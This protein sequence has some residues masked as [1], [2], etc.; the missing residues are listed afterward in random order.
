MLETLSFFKIQLVFGLVLGCACALIGVF[1]LLQRLTVFGVTLSQAATSATAVSLFLGLQSAHG[2]AGMG[3]LANDLL[4]L[5][6][7]TLFML[8]FFFVKLRNP[9]NLSAI[10]VGGLVF[11]AALSQ[12]LIA[13]GGRVQ[14]HLLRAFFGNI[15]T[16]SSDEWRHLWIPGVVFLVFFLYYYRSILS[17]SFDRDHARLTGIK[18]FWIDLL[19]FMM[20]CVVC[21]LS[22]NLMGSFY[23]LAHLILPGLVALAISR[24]VVTTIGVAVLYSATSTLLGFLLSLYKIPVGLG[25]LNLPTSSTIIM[26]MCV[27]LPVF[28]FAGRLWSGTFG[29]KHHT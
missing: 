12:L 6:L 18:V 20:L 14:N 22:I 8:P 7:T 23:S 4:I 28:L 15:L 10:L 24:S 17:V 25:G 26:V 13:L 2:G 21:S 3:G 5:F 19:F 29:R 16:V 9:P 11:F 1:V 27:M